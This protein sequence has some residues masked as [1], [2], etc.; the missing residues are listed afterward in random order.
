LLL[1]IQPSSHPPKPLIYSCPLRSHLTHLSTLLPTLHL[2]KPLDLLVSTQA[3]FWYI[4]PFCCPPESLIYSRPLRSCLT[5]SFSFNSLPPGLHQPK[6]LIYLRLLR[7][8]LVHLSTLLPSLHPPVALDL[9]M[10]TQATSWHICRFCRPLEPL[11]YSHPLGP[12]LMHSSTRS[13]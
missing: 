2:L 12:C 11:I 13:S 6:P 1:S 8:C 10:S 9:L 5:H 7:S 3:A 4:R